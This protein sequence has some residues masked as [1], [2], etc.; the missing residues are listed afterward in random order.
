MDKDWIKTIT[1]IATMIAGFWTVFIHI[2]NRLDSIDSRLAKVEGWIEGR[3]DNASTEIN[4]SETMTTDS[5]MVSVSMEAT[6][7]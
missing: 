3:F 2:D 6:N 5:L 4:S 1:I 7:D